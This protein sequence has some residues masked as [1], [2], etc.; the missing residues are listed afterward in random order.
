[1]ATRRRSSATATPVKKSSSAKISVTKY[2]KPHEIVMTETPISE[3]SRPESTKLTLNDY[4]E[5]FKVRWQ[6]HSYEVDELISDIKKGW[7]FS[8]PYVKQAID[9]TVK[10]YK[11]LQ[12]RFQTAE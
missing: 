4:K 10:T 3:K 9:Y 12:T 7:K 8:S 6:I 5:D 11:N 2:T 1:M